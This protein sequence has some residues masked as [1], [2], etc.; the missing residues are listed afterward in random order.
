MDPSV[1]I[2]TFLGVFLVNLIPIFGPPTWIVL[3]FIAIFYPIPS[4][5][6]FVLTALVAAVLGRFFLILFS[7]HIVRNRFFSKRYIKN[8]EYLRKHFE[9]RAYLPSLIFF[10]DAITPLPSDQLFIAYG[11]TGHKARYALVPFAIGRF[12]TYSFWA[13]NATQLS[14]E[15]ALIVLKNFSFFNIG[16]IGM[17]ILLLALLYFYIKI[18]WEYLV[19][20]N[21]FRFIDHNH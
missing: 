5:I 15:P 6:L 12:F 19:V 20:K 8:M 7:K 4:F 18:D 14:K 13:F 16:F 10:I 21:R 17:E 3:S 2:Y 1:F 11:L 9:K